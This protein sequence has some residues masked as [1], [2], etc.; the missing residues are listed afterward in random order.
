MFACKNLFQGKDLPSG[1][2]IPIVK[3]K[4]MVIVVGR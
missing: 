4:I 3:I 1:T 2:G